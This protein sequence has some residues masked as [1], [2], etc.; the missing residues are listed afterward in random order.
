FFNLRVFFQGLG[1]RFAPRLLSLFGSGL[2]FGERGLQR[3]V[4]GD[5]LQRVDHVVVGRVDRVTHAE[6]ALR[7]QEQ[8]VLDTP[9]FVV[10]RRTVGRGAARAVQLG[11]GG[12]DEVDG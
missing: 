5:G 11:G 1:V 12:L 2:I 6:P 7:V 4:V 3:G 8:E 10:V 9:R